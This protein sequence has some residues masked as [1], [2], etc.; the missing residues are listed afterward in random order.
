MTPCLDPIH[1][2]LAPHSVESSCAAPQQSRPP[3]LRRAATAALVTLALTGCATTDPRDPLEPLNRG[4]YAVN[5]ALDRTVIR[6][7]AEVY[8]A[9]VPE[10]GRIGVSNFFGNI[11]DFWNAVNN[12]L[13]GKVSTAVSDVGR[14]ALNSTVGL[15]GFVDVA[16]RVGL[17]KSDEDLGQ[18][19]GW[20][21]VPAGPY[22][23]M[24]LLGPSSLRD[25]PATVVQIVL[26]PQT[27]YIEES[28]HVW[29][30]WALR[31]LNNRA[32]L[33]GANRVLETAATDRYAFLRDA[34][35]QR[36]RSQIWDGNPPRE[37][38]SLTPPSV[39]QLE[40]IWL[41]AAAPAPGEQ[42]PAVQSES[43]SASAGDRSGTTLR[44]T[45]TTFN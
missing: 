21:G 10:P 28:A 22:I 25:A 33:L 32:N 19:L 15:L 44:V 14:I 39:V 20:W 4:I 16:S 38:G 29:S 18:T 30:L 31:L 42:A 13:Q 9:V 8:T 43:G 34:Y 27:V 3:M 11:Y 37:R 2:P 23:M 41:R 35:F 24:P 36:R 12:L 45:Q 17:E 6:P 26:D 7:A 1:T 5:D 40:S